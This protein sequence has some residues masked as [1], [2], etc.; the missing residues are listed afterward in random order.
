MVGYRV[1][2]GF[3]DTVVG[4]RVMHGKLQRYR[5]LT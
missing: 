1:M 3:R 4:Y 2:D 5:W